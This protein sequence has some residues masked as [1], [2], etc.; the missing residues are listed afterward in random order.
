MANDTL[1]SK[2]AKGKLDVGARILLGIT[3]ELSV[4]ISRRYVSND[5]TMVGRETPE[6]L[7]TNAVRE[8][9]LGTHTTV[10]SMV[11]STNSS[12]KL[13][14][15]VPSP[16]RHAVVLTL[17]PINGIINESPTK[18]GHGPAYNETRYDRTNETDE[19][20][21][22]WRAR[23]VS[24]YD[25]KL[26]ESGGVEEHGSHEPGHA[27]IIGESCKSNSR[28]T[29]ERGMGVEE[30]ATAAANGATVTK[31]TR[32]VETTDRRPNKETKRERNRAKSVSCIANVQS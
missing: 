8:C 16:S 22:G 31:S 11:A 18:V 3:V 2:E 7:S 21:A 29:S 25:S 13:E 24:R 26:G 5:V 19:A 9:N 20:L 28:N 1:S 6:T 30:G 12:F 27:A 4:N 32:R 10:A 14:K 23:D 15:D 17:D